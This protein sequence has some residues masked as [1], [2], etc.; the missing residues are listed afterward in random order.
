MA[1][2]G[3]GQVFIMQQGDDPDTRF[4]LTVH[5]D[6][7]DPRGLAPILLNLKEDGYKHIRTNDVFIRDGVLEV[8]EAP[9]I[10]ALGFRS[11]AAFLR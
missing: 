11:K 5:T 1:Y 9:A 6:V 10:P 3:P 4:G 7:E 8:K 2:T